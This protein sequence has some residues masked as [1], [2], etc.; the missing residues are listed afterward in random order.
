MALAL[1]PERKPEQAWSNVVQPLPFAP[2]GG[3]LEGVLPLSL[4][5]KA[6]TIL[7]Q[8]HRLLAVLLAER[9]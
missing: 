3:R 1:A 4:V 7:M 2:R 8:G 5:R 9:R 6:T